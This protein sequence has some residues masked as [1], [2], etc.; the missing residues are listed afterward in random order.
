[1]VIEGDAKM[2]ADIREP[3]RVNIPE[4]PGLFHGT[5]E[6]HLRHGD[7]CMG[8]AR[9]EHGPVEALVMG[10]D[11]IDLTK[12]RGNMA[13]Q[14]SEGRLIFHLFPGDAMEIIKNKLFLWGPDEICSLVDYPAVF[15]FYKPQGAGAG[16]LVIGSLEIYGKESHIGVFTYAREY[17]A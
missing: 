9:F 14:F 16:A 1:M 2:A 12:K 8:A 3:G 7:P 15:D 10:H 5:F 13:P 17:P 11:E 6:F 4:F